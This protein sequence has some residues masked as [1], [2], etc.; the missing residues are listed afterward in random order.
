MLSL[1]TFIIWTSIVSVKQALCGV[2][3]DEVIIPLFHLLIAGTSIRFLTFI[4]SQ[5]HKHKSQ[6]KYKVAA[7]YKAPFFLYSCSES[8]NTADD[9]L[10]GGKRERMSL[11]ECC[12]NSHWT[13]VL[14]LQHK[15]RSYCGFMSG[16]I[17]FNSMMSSTVFSIPSGWTLTEVCNSWKTC[18]SQ[19]P[20]HEHQWLQWGLLR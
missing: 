6:Q 8:Q 5:K 16:L 10:R 1:G 14:H 19:F 18:F 17:F 7:I 4:A 15:K 13:C 20:C 9:Y 3:I 2:I 11:L 12:R